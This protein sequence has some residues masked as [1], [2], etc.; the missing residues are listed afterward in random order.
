MDIRKAV[1]DVHRVVMAQIES[2]QVALMILRHISTLPSGPG[3]F[4]QRF[5]D[6]L[7][8]PND[9]KSGEYSIADPIF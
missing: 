2:R 3:D 5:I 4:G 1:E 7:V 9:L 8:D 6:L